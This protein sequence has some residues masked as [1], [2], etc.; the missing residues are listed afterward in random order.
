MKQV[1][2]MVDKVLTLRSMWWEIRWQTNGP[3]KTARIFVFKT[4]KE[5]LKELR[6]IRKR[7]PDRTYFLCCT[8]EETRIEFRDN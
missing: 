5:G 8:R 4:K 7:H 3:K 1:R 2:R 6:A